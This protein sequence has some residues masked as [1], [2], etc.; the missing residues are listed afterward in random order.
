[1]PQIE[2]WPRILAAI[3]DQLVERMH[4]RNVGPDD[5]G[6]LPVWLETRPNVREG[7][8]FKDFGSFKLCGE[9]KYPKTFLLDGQAARGEKL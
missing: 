5:L 8:C 4:D 7:R 3:R 1:M 9:G 6:R 2:T